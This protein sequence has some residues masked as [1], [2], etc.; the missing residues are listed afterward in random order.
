MSYWEP[1]R[2]CPPWGRGGGVIIGGLAGRGGNQWALGTPARRCRGLCRERR[3]GGGHAALLPGLRE[4]ADRRGGAALPPLRLQHLPLRAQRHAQGGRSQ[5]GGRRSRQAPARPGPSPPPSPP[6]SAS[7]GPCRPPQALRPPR[8][9][10]GA[11]A[12][13]LRPGRSSPRYPC[14]SSLVFLPEGLFK[15]AASFSTSLF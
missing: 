10:P 6:G 9:A 7:C 8:A 2:L 1:A 4:R 3:A 5:R 14:H 12:A 11:C 13:L 15:I